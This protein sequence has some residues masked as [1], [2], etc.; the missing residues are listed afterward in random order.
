MK[1]ALSSKNKVSFINGTLPQPPLT[2]PDFELWDRCNNMVLSWITR[3]LSPHIAQSAICFDTASELWLDLQ[4]RFTKGNHFRFSEL[5]K[6]LHSIKQGDSSLSTYFTD[7]K[8]LWDELEF[9]RPTP[10]CTCSPR[11][12]CSLSS[13]VQ[14]YKHSEYITCFLKGLNENYNNVRTQILLMDPLPSLSKAYSLV[15]QQDPTPLPNPPE[16]AILAVH[17]NNISQGKPHNVQGKGKGK[18]QPRTSM[19]CSN[20][21]KTNHTVENC[22]FKYGFP[23]GYKSRTQMNNE[24]INEGKK[25][26]QGSSTDASNPLS[27]EDYHYL[28]NLLK[29][30][31]IEPSTPTKQQLAD[32]TSHLVSSISKTGYGYQE[33]DWECG[34]DQ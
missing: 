23:P 5:L 10:S 14:R 24:A 22:Y 27:R 29:S 28:V 25:T 34:A 16:S 4:D 33:D 18:W 30:S 7:L 12:S 20:C 21:N 13:A 6:D 26:N 9:L 19:L 32:Q 31:R 2:D 15:V 8:I 3:T 1:R 17:S 11:C